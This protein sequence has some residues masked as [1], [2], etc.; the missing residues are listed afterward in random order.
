MIAVQCAYFH[1]HGKADYVILEGSWILDIPSHV[2]NC[3]LSRLEG[4]SKRLRGK[5]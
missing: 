3:E 5:R 4:L 1:V 2:G